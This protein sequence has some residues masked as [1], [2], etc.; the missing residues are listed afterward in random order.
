MT[1][2]TLSKIIST[3]AIQSIGFLSIGCGDGS[4]QNLVPTQATSTIQ[5]QVIGNWSLAKIDDQAIDSQDAALLNVASSVVEEPGYVV[6]RFP[7]CSGSVKAVLHPAEIKLLSDQSNDCFVH[8]TVSVEANRAK[9]SD[10]LR[11]G[12]SFNLADDST[13]TLQNSAGT[14]VFIKAQ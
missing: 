1:R 2:Q 3:V 12:A 7:D 14:L 11:N 6:V 5:D 10:V 4:S 8:F 9:I 13:L